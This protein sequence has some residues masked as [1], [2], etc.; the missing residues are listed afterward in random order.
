MVFSFSLGREL[1]II[2]IIFSPFLVSSSAHRHRQWWWKRLRVRLQLWTGQLRVQVQSPALKTHR[3]WK[4]S[5]IVHRNPQEASL[6]SAHLLIISLIN[7]PHTWLF[8]HMHKIQRPLSAT[9]C[10]NFATEQ[11]LPLSKSRMYIF[12]VNGDRLWIALS[13]VQAIKYSK[14]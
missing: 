7:V 8:F 12:E 1:L 11:L 3:K 9:L 4:P 2:L 13:G 10:Q 5:T 14:L 6:H